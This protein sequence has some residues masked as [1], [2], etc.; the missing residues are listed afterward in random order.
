MSYVD[1]LTD[2]VPS[3]IYKRGKKYYETNK[4]LDYDISDG[5]NKKFSLTAEVKGTYNYQVEID[6]S[7]EGDEIHFENDCTCPYDWGSICKHEVAVLYKFLNE[8]YHLLGLPVNDFNS[9]TKLEELSESVQTT[10][11]IPLQYYIKGLA[12]DAMVNFKLTLDSPNCPIN[13][14][15]SIIDYIQASYAY[16]NLDQIV[17]GLSHN[18][19]V[20]IEYLSNTE[21]SKSQTPGALLFPKSQANF[22]F[23]LRLMT[24]NEVY[25]DETKKR[26]KKGEVIYPDLILEGNLDQV[27]IKTKKFDYPIYEGD[28]HQESRL[29]WTVIDSQVHPLEFNSIEQIPDNILIPKEKQGEFLFEILPSL[30]EELE[31]EIDEELEGYQLN[32]KPPEIK[33][34]FDYQDNNILSYSEVKLGD[35][36]YENSE[37]L[38]FDSN[39]KCYTQMEDDPKEW[40]SL[41]TKPIE[42]LINY[43]EDY[44]FHVSPNNF[45]IKDE[46]DIQEFITEGIDNLPTEWDVETTTAFDEVEVKPVELEP[47]VELKDDDEDGTIDWFEFKVKYNLGGETYTYQELKKLLR[48]NKAGDNYLRV[49]NQYLILEDDKQEQEINQLLELAESQG[50]A[51]YR[52]SYYNLL[53]YRNL[54]EET[55]INFVGNQVYNELNEDITADN[56][57]KEVDIPIKAKDILRDYQKQGYYWLRFLNKYH[58]GGILADDMGLGK[59]LQTL[60]LLKSLSLNKPALI[61]CPRTLIYNWSEEIKKFFPQFEH[62]VYYGS[63]TDREEMRQNFNQYQVLITSYSIISRDYLDLEDFSFSYVVLDEA[64]HIKNRRTKRAKGVKMIKAKNRLALTGTPIENSLEELWSIFDFLMPG[65]LGNYKEFRRK[66]LKPINQENNQ[67]EL[68]ELKER[69]AP[70]ILR[71]KKEE[72]LTELPDKIINIQPVQMSKGQEDTYRLILKEVKENLVKTVEERGFNRSQINILVALTKLRQVCD[73]PRLILD[74][75]DKKLSSGKLDVLLEI[76]QDAIAGGHKLIVF[77][78]FVKMLKL[79]KNRF[80]KNG[81]E[82]EYLDGSTRNRME[83][84]NRFNQ[85]SD[86]NAFLISLKAGGTGLNLTS[87]DIVIHV[88]PWWNPMVERQATDR[89]HRI[90]Q[91]NQ[92]I[93]Y[94]LITTGTVEEKI[95]KLQKRKEAIFENVIENNSN[96]MDEISWQDIQELLEYD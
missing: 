15:D 7:L 67:E 54:I 34:K 19:I 10:K 36:V 18:D 77:S 81:I 61:I 85:S 55:G 90:G 51:S 71:R 27:E 89:A 72:V 3:K 32:S 88:D 86:V 21:T 79:I 17:S 73:H 29:Q 60:T 33:V 56:L 23:L 64:H 28:L 48:Q 2:Y 66:Y 57:I 41:D 26:V 44:E 42:N 78:Q 58:F 84:V 43:L 1:A 31:L 9:F 20:N 53:Y 70:F 12:I 25:L 50:D 22:N 6:L 8:D 74:D 65:Y 82:F 39:N 11:N 83:R 45:N 95:L 68:L 63:P 46:S 30:K 13:K 80:K 94:K 24:E 59:T 91:E 16:Q 38:G 52:S 47:I 75:S 35:E 62:L 5:G 93:V 87:A 96:P 4:I 92:V 37:I 14:L 76:V 49:G 69:I 40:F